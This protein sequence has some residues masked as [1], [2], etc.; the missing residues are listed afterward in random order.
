MNPGERV[1]I[2]DPGFQ[3]AYSV[4][5]SLGARL[6]PVPIDKYGAAPQR[7]VFRNARLLYRRLAIS[8]LL[9]SRCLS[10]GESKF[11]NMHETLEP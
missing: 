5:E 2:E 4:F 3:V 9:G 10:D 6:Q 8:F 11:F 7:H 1:L